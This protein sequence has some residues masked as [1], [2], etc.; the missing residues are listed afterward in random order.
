MAFAWI[1][2]HTHLFTEAT[3]GEHPAL[4]DGKVNTVDA[5]LK[6]FATTLPQGIVVVDY[7]RAASSEHVMV[8][9]R[10]LLARGI[11][12]R[13]VIRANIHDS[14]TEEWL[15][16]PQV[17]GARLYA[18]AEAPDI[19][20]NKAAFDRLFTQLRSRKQHLCLFGKPALLRQMLAQIPEDIT[21]LI[22]HLGVPDA[23]QGSNH[24]DYNQLLAD[25]AARNK[26]A[27]G[28]GVFVKGPGYRTSLEPKRVVPFLS[29]LIEKL[30]ESQILLGAS[31]APFAGAVMESFAPFAGKQNTDF[32]GYDKIIPWLQ[33]VINLLAAE[34]P[35]KSEEMWQAQLLYHNAERLYG[36]SR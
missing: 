31:D 6:G 30:G 8:T 25:L 14:R 26:R 10:D 1:D 32:M 12:A 5:Y 24:Y 9:L 35:R 22:D 29:L 19:I 4:I 20:G 27:G 16:H 15:K 34:Y 33:I 21:L 2:T 3:K 28:A 7:S 11:A 13:G 36:F 18:L 17:A 23:A